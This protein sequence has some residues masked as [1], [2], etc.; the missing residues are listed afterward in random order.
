[1][2]G[3]IGVTSTIGEGSRFWFEVTFPG[4]ASC[5]SS[6]NADRA[7]ESALLSETD[8]PLSLSVRSIEPM[9]RGAKVLLV[10]DNM[11]NQK[12]AIAMLNMLGCDIDLADDGLVAVTK[13]DEDTYD[14]ILMDCQMP[15]MDGFAATAAIRAKEEEEQRA[16]PTPVIAVTANALASDRERCLAAGMNDYVS[17]PFRLGDLK[18]AIERWLPATRKIESPAPKPDL[19]VVDKSELDELREFGVSDAEL[20]E[21]VTCYVDTSTASLSSMNDA[22]AN[23]DRESLRA[24]AHKLKGGSG[25]VGALTVASI[26]SELQA[27]AE[28]APWEALTDMVSRLTREVPAAHDELTEKYGPQTS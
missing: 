8:L 24:L 27:N 19:T 11:A 12:V 26:C 1:M 9:Q 17:K 14:V 2:G 16:S 6:R 13:F 3:R 25:Q 18:E 22:I 23:Q 5:E 21:I 20:A 10:E 4:V 28:S 15:N 7:I